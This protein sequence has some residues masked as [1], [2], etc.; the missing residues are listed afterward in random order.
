MVRAEP[1][2]VL[3][4]SPFLGASA[5]EWVARELDQRGRR[6][7]VPSLRA[8]AGE[9]Y[10]PRRDVRQAVEAVAADDARTV[11]L[12]ERAMLAGA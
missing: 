10:Q 9:P 12:V 5:W 2:I 8:A 6:A 11:V 4:H 7:I 1:P 3:V